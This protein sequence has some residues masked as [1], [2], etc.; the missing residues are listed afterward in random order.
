MALVDRDGSK[1]DILGYLDA[2][3][4]ECVIELSVV[5]GGEYVSFE[6]PIRALG[7]KRL[8]ACSCGGNC[9]SD[10]LALT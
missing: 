5:R 10:P 7:G 6:A 4:L 3:V 2:V 8:G 1:E 9:Q